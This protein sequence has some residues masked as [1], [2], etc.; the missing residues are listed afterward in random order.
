MSMS[1]LH[2]ITANCGH[3]VVQVLYTYRHGSL[4]FRTLGETDSMKSG[5]SASGVN[6]DPCVTYSGSPPRELTHVAIYK[7][8][9][10]G[11]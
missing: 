1:G 7:G 6:K 9:T 11:S 5:E 4:K 2:L 8:G 3:S 10:N